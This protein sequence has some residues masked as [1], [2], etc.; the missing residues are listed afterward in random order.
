MEF[1]AVRPATSR[2]LTA[3]ADVVLPAATHVEE[4]GSFVQ[5][6]AIIQRFRRAYPPRAET[7]GHWKWAVDIMREFGF[8]V[9]YASARDVFRE[10]SGT[11]PRAGAVRL[12]PGGASPQD[13]ARALSLC[14]PPPTAG[15]PATENSGRPASGAFEGLL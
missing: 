11:V 3:Q 7:Q 2:A 10:L 14:P 9:T 1:I 12:G 6:D 5:A 8:P 15:P 4:E 13:D